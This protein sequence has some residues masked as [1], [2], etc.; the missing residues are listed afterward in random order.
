LLDNE[1]DRLNQ[2]HASIDYIDSNPIKEEAL[3]LEKFKKSTERIFKKSNLTIIMFQQLSLL[4]MKNDNLNEKA[5]MINDLAE[6]NVNKEILES[7]TNN[8]D[9]F[10]DSC[11][12]KKNISFTYLFNKK[13]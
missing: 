9:L 1:N 3:N 2:Y 7:L 12:S 11:K 10:D 5:N 4:K 8:I 13:L 6:E